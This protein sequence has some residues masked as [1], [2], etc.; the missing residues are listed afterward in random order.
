MSINPGV[1]IPFGS[2][3]LG[4]LSKNTPAVNQLLTAILKAV[5]T[6]GAHK[7]MGRKQGVSWCL[8]FPPFYSLYQFLTLYLFFCLAS[9]D[10]GGR[11][12]I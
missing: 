3:N 11:F 2:K 5:E 1:A 8:I 7:F 12:V 9:M 4:D 10:S 6:V